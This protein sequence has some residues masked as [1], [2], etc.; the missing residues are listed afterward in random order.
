MLLTIF[1]LSSRFKE[2]SSERSSSS[3]QQYSSDGLYPRNTRLTVG[4]ILKSF[5]RGFERALKRIKSSKQKSTST[6]SVGERPRKDSGPSKTIFDPQGQ[7]L[8]TWNKFFVLSCVASV[9]LDPFFFYIPVMKNVDEN[10]CFDLDDRVAKY[11]CVFRTFIDAFYALHIIFQFR[12]GFI[13]P[14]SRVFGRGELNVDP[15]AI[16][17]RYLFS[18]F[19]IDFLSILPLPQVCMHAPFAFIHLRPHVVKC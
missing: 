14:S 15:K 5:W 2:W 1:I 13:A 17:K 12:T 8:Q 11:T 3:E 10:R 19:I 6:H 7:F 4:R 18:Y 9:A 16:A